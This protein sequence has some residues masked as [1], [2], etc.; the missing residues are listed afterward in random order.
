MAPLLI[1]RVSSASIVSIEST[2][3]PSKLLQLS[4]PQ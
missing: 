1:D 4:T 2:G 3:D